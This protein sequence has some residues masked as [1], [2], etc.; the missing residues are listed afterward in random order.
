MGHFE[1]SGRIVHVS[2]FCQTPVWVDEA[3]T[4]T[5]TTIK[6]P[7]P[8][9]TWQH[10]NAW[11]LVLPWDAGEDW[12]NCW[13]ANGPQWWKGRGTTFQ[14]HQTPRE[15]H[16]ATGRLWKMSVHGNI[17]TIVQWTS[18]FWFVTMAP[19]WSMTWSQ[20]SGIATDIMLW[21]KP[22]GLSSG[23]KVICHPLL[24]VGKLPSKYKYAWW[25]PK[26][27]V[28]PNHPFY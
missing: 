18:L 2:P 7:L 4:Q 24:L 20:Q 26:I 13:R 1:E 28:S 12:G 6:L 21:M 19:T 23:Q 22:Q 5:E 17:V 10:P 11:G 25:F 14:Q 16:A 15:R 3:Q 8:W 27:R 9:W